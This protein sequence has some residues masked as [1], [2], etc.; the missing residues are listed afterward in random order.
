MAVITITQTDL[1]ASTR[2]EAGVYPAMMTKVDCKPSKS[3][4][5]TNFW[6]SFTIIDGQYKGKEHLVLYTTAATGDG[7]MLD[8]LQ[9]ITRTDLARIKAAINNE[10]VKPGEIETDELLNKPLDLIF[11]LMIIGGFPINAITGYAPLGKGSS[12]PF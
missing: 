10:S 12:T 1:L 5:G 3:G 8:K 9:T 11:G 7:G 2:L 6:I 4:K